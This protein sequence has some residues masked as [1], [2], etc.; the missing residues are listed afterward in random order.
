MHEITTTKSLTKIYRSVLGAG[1]VK[2]LANK[3]PY[4]FVEGAQS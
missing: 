3:A 2:A 4:R 1:E